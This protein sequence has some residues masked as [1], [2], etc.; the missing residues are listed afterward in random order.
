MLSGD[1]LGL[2]QLPDPLWQ[3]VGFERLQLRRSS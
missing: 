1:P 2:G 3:L